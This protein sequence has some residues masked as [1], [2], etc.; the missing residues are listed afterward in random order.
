MT[1]DALQSHTKSHL[2]SGPSRLM[3][4]SLDNDLSFACSS[5]FLHQVVYQN[6]ALLTALSSIFSGNSAQRLLKFRKS[7]SSRSNTFYKHSPPSE[8]SCTLPTYHP[9]DYIHTHSDMAPLNFAS[10][11]SG[12]TSNPQARPDAVSEWYGYFLL[13]RITRTAMSC[14][15][16]SSPV[17]SATCSSPLFETH[18]HMPLHHLC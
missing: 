13:S 16:V 8:T 10:A 9:L 4:T 6:I 14:E 11:A 7:L 2:P 1:P 3:R 17:A 15:H 18:E 5:E 12:N